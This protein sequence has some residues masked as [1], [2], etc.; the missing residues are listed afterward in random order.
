MRRRIAPAAVAT[1][2]VATVA[3][4]SCSASDAKALCE[5][6]ISEG[7]LSSSV[8]VTGESPD[9]LRVQLNGDVP[10]LNSQRSVLQ[11]GDPAD[12]ELVVG[13]GFIVGANL[14]YVDAST[15]EVLD[16][17]P[18]FGSG[19]AS[20]LFLASAEG[21]SLVAATL[22][23]RPGDTLAIALSP[24]ESAGM[25]VENSLVVIAEIVSAYEGRVEGKSRSLPF[26]FPAVTN[27]ETGRPGI[28][29]PPQAPPSE[30]RS[31]LRV[32]GDG[33]RVEAGDTV[34]GQILA[35]DWGGSVLNNSWE[36]SPQSFGTEDQ[37]GQ[38]GATFR[39]ALTGMPIGSQL[40][41]IEPGNGVPTVSVI[42][43]LAVA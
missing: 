36:Q 8:A 41:V 43:I 25:G 4:T 23:A 13:E 34:I 22:C 12:A 39:A 10:A 3:L 32:E 14:A 30:T 33:P 37:I 18:G 9:T 20:D 29:L 21:S 19:K 1:A 7:A 5:P 16:V 40:V 27:D 38:S 6:P 31:A 26:G 11:A 35:V 17:S 15:G 24:Q 42:D 28:V 2:L